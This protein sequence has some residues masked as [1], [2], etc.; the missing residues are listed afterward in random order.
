MVE[1][2]KVLEEDKAKIAQDYLKA[3]TEALEKSNRAKVETTIKHLLELDLKALLLEAW[4]TQEL[5]FLI[6]LKR[7][8]YLE[9]LANK[10][11]IQ[12]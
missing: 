12:A 6:E 2:L 3:Q 4:G 5:P 8:Q 1:Q 11:P 10:Q 7:V 9:R